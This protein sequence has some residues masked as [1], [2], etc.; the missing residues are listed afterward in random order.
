MISVRLI[1][2]L[3]DWV[4]HFKSGEDLSFDAV[5]VEVDCSSNGA[6]GFPAEQHVVGQVSITS[7]RD[8]GLLLRAKDSV[9]SQDV[10]VA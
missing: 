6:A 5:L 2:R 3:S 7:L 8:L 10:D 4:R 9:R 1:L